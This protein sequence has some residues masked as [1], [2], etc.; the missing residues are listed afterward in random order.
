MRG[1]S[2]EK[3]Q[4]PLLSFA[5]ETILSAVRCYRPEAA[6]A[7]TNREILDVLFVRK[8][9]LLSPITLIFAPRSAVNDSIAH[10]V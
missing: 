8:F 1:T 2:R 4:V 5:L 6:L 9:H 10:P 7:S 3:G